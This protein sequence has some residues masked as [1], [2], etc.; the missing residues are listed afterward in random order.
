MYKRFLQLDDIMKKKS[1]FL[2]G[3]RQTGK[4]SLCKTSFEGCKYVDL[5]EADTFRT[6]NTRPELLRLSLNPSDKLIVIDEIQKCIPLLD[7]VQLMIDRDKSLRFLLT[8]SSA[9]K[10]KRGAANLLPGRVWTQKFH[11][12]VFPED[13]NDALSMR[14][15]YGGL[16]GVLSSA[17]PVDELQN[18]IGS[19]LKEEIQAEGLTRNIG[20]FARFLDIAGDSN[21][22]QMNYSTISSQ[23][24]IP[25]KTVRDYFQ[26]L[27]DT[28]IAD[29]I[30]VFNKKSIRKPASTPK[31]YFFDVGV[32]NA[33]RKNLALQ[34]SS[35]EMGKRLEHL[36]YC[37]LVAFRDYVNGDLELTY[38][39]TQ[40][41][42]EVDFVLNDKVAIEVKNSEKV[43]KSDIKGLLALKQ[44]FPTMKCLV[45]SNTLVNYTEDGVEHLNVQKFL[46]ELWGG[47]L[48]S[49]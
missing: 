18:Y 26:V 14:L 28:N 8:G 44:E 24:G 37:E 12:L 11:P 45:V 27:Q 30:P 25:L 10:L 6:L 4:S 1:H 42:L 16:P 41:K 19:Y 40:D 3:P 38:W 29:L 31:C 9:R 23:S 39:R 17:D 46:T 13:Q 43:R 49:G 47:E 22:E 48:F 7:E 21:C 34:T 32:A 15:A 33:L 5:L 35:I 20:N 2:I 36:I